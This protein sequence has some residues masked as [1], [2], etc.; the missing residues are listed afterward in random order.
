[1]ISIESASQRKI[2]VVNSTI[3]SKKRE[4]KADDGWEFFIKWHKRSPQNK[5]TETVEEDCLSLR[6]TLHTAKIVCFLHPSSLS[7]TLSNFL[8]SFLLIFF[9]LQMTLS[10]LVWERKFSVTYFLYLFFQFTR[11]SFLNTT[12]TSTNQKTKNKIARGEHLTN[13]SSTF[14]H[15]FNL[16]HF[17]RNFSAIY[18]FVLH[19]WFTFDTV[20]CYFLS[21][22]LFH[23][24]CYKLF[25]VVTVICVFVCVCWYYL[26]CISFVLGHLAETLFITLIFIDCLITT[27]FVSCVF[28]S[29]NTTS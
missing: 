14:P 25:F 23:C 18:Y 17:Y 16:I 24:C 19:F 9:F 2:D 26:I 11:I 12:H 15:T 21:F 8:Y 6:Y 10:D 7:H 5:N 1:M 29:N 4:S 22:C 27:P 13:F 20:C 3:M 28:T